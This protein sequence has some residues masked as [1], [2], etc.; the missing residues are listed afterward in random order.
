MSTS[1]SSPLDP[2]RIRVARGAQGVQ[3]GPRNLRSPRGPWSPRAPGLKMK[4]PGFTRARA[5][6]ARYRSGLAGSLVAGAYA[7]G[8]HRLRTSHRVP[9][10][11][12]AEPYPESTGF[13]SSAVNNKSIKPTSFLVGELDTG[14]PHWLALLSG[15]PHDSLPAIRGTSCPS[16][17]LEE[18]AAFDC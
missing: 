10:L 15:N 5:F 17:S 6:A 18:T 16:G 2:V 9:L 13:A 4:N 1:P 14:T 7:T 8:G 11:P 3:W 12:T